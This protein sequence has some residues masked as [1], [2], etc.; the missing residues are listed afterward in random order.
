MGMMHWGY[1]EPPLLIA[2]ACTYIA[3]PDT[4]MHYVHLI[5]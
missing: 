2:P 3:W 1:H 5:A 4:P